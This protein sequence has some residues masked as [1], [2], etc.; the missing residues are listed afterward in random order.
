VHIVFDALEVRRAKM[1]MVPY[2]VVGATRTLAESA[3][4]NAPQVYPRPGRHR[5]ARHGRKHRR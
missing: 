1:L 4:P 5:E 2:A 3:L